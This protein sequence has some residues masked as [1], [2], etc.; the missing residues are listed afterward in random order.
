ML[1]VEILFKVL[2]FLGRGEGMGQRD[3]AL[4]FVVF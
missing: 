3:F 2:R 1:A 4:C